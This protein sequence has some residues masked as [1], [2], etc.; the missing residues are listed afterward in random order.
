MTKLPEID[1]DQIMADC[2]KR[3]RLRSEMMPDEQS[4]LNQLFEAY[5][6]LKELGFNDACYCPKD[7]S[8]FE[9]IE[10]GCTAI[11]N[12]CHY[13]GEW[14]KGTWWIA[15]DGDLWPSH[16]ILYRPNKP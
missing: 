2:Q 10:V 5:Q 12:N 15:S 14:P 8:S 7:G 4:A 11:A 3:E 16:P 13:S 6:R 1:V 9:A